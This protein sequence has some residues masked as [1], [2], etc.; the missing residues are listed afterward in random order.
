MSGYMA[1]RT[2]GRG[3]HDY[4]EDMGNY[5]RCPRCGSTRSKPK[6]Q[7]GRRGAWTA[8]GHYASAPKQSEPCPK[9]GGLLEA[10]R[11]TGNPAL[12]FGDAGAPRADWD[13]RVQPDWRLARA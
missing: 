10:R 4:S 7:Q 1:G 11:E 12:G 6:A 9:C 13:P 8:D 2:C 5:L 3:K